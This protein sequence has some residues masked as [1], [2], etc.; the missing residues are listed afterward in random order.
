VLPLAK[1]AVSTAG[2][3]RQAVTIG[4]TRYSNMLDPATG[5]GLTHFIAATVIADTATTSSALATACCEAGPDIARESLDK[6]GGRAARI[7]H[8]QEGQH[9]V[10]LIGEF[11]Q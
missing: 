5:L 1:T 9:V 10:M 7:V 8:E 11:P 3:M 2:G 4:K 6:W